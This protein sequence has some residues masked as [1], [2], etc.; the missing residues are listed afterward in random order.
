MFAM[1]GYIRAICMTEKLETRE[2]I[3]ESKRDVG[4]FVEL[5]LITF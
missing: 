5:T 1:A 2:K 3:Q 4:L